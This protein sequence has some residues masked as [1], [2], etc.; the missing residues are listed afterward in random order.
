M[1]YSIL[2]KKLNDGRTDYEITYKNAYIHLIVGKDYYKTDKQS[3][4]FDLIL[5]HIY[6]KWD[7]NKNAA[8]KGLARNLLCKLLLE[9]IEKNVINKKSIILLEAEPSL[10]EKLLDMY[11]GMGFKVKEYIDKKKYPEFKN[12][13]FKEYSDGAV[14]TATVSKVLSWC[15]KKYKIQSNKGGNRKLIKKRKSAKKINSLKQ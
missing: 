5:G 9:L 7:K 6:S 14:M 13:K 10:K 8:P 1:E 3:I 4:E 11:K 2:N 15:S 12:N